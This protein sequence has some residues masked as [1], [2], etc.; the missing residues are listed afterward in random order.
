[1]KRALVTLSA[2]LL[3]A[4]CAT[5][6]V[7]PTPPA[8]SPSPPPSP[9]PSPTPE[10]KSLTVCLPREP[11]SLYLYGAE[12]PAAHHIW[13]AIYDGPI[14]TRHYAH[15]P[16]ILREL[17]SLDNDAVQVKTVLVEDGDRALDASGR[18]VTLTPGVMVETADGQRVVVDRTPI[19]MQQMEVTFTLRSDLRWSDG[20]PLTADDSVYSFQLAADPA[21]PTDKHIVERTADY[22]ALDEATVIWQG[23]PGFL[24]PA[25]LLNFWHPLPRH[26]WNH[27][28]A[29][30][31]ISSD[32]STREPL[33]WGPFAVRDWTPGERLTV[34][35]NWFYF[36]A[37]EGLPRLDEVTFRFLEVPAPLADELLTGGCDVVTHE[38]AEAVLDAMEPAAILPTVEVLATQDTA[39]ELLAFGISPAPSH[40]RPDLFEDVR[41][42]RG[43]AQCIDRR[44]IV[45]ALSTADGRIPDSYLPPEHPL[46]ADD[47]LATWDY[48]PEAGKLLLAQAGWY[49]EDGDGLREAHNVPGIADGTPFQVTYHTPEAA[50]RLRTA[51]LVRGDLRAC[52]ILV[53]VHALAPEDLFA[54]GPEGVLLGRRFDLAQFSWRTSDVPLCDLFLS[55]QIPGQG[56]WSKPNVAGFIDGEF[57]EACQKALRALPNKPDHV[58]AHAEAQRIFSEQIPVLPLFRH[59]RVTLARTFVIGLLPAPGQPSELWNL[60]Q[61]DVRR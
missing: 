38:A 41:V 51:A 58:V 44:A 27:L 46:H 10:P 8:P 3:S 53:S 19:P 54:P 30:E 1:M 18:V 59:Q 57:D 4:A 17:P 26:A 50:P 16:V 28:T 6:T 32:V 61:V 9:R 31:L 5:P 7:L 22:R 37:E 43:I 29:T 13:E 60:E 35:R 40:D 33:G 15:Q 39:W 34:E 55:S 25:Y 23:V 14:D 56:D 11:D 20:A 36:R 24:D 52:G 2:L 42:R 48:D 47:G 49:D 45:D 12:D 21:T